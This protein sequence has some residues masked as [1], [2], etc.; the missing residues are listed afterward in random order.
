MS[1]TLTD[2]MS[3]KIISQQRTSLRLRDEEILRLHEENL[4]LRRAITKLTCLIAELHDLTTDI[5]NN[6]RQIVDKLP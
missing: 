1:N 3:K 4:Q 2:A 5:D 6:A